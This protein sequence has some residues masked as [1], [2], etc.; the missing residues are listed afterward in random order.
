[1]ELYVVT[2]DFEFAPELFKSFLDFHRLQLFH[3]YISMSV[4]LSVGPRF[5]QNYYTYLL[6]VRILQLDKLKRTLLDIIS[7]KL[8]IHSESLFYYPIHLSPSTGNIRITNI[9]SYY[10]YMQ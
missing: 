5:L 7:E 2:Q 8:W 6:Y 4:R 1:M 10:I 9:D 3:I